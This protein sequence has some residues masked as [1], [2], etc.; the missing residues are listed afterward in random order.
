M[1]D[2]E[3][4]FPINKYFCREKS[5]SGTQKVD[6]VWIMGLL[7]FRGCKYLICH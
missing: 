2:S 3:E 7:N 5:E 6:F 1:G 4:I